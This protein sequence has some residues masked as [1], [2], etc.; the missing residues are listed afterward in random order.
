MGSVGVHAF[1]RLCVSCRGN[2]AGSVHLV[3]LM[4]HASRTAVL[5]ASRH[6][7]QMLYFLVVQH[8]LRTLSMQVDSCGSTQTASSLKVGH[9]C[10]HG[11]LALLPVCAL[12]SASALGVGTAMKA[13]AGAY[14]GSSD[15]Y[16]VHLAGLLIS[17]LLQLATASAHVV[18]LCHR[19]CHTLWRICYAAA[20]S[21][22]TVSL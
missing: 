16:E 5:V 8:L 18:H 22:G 21:S 3:G 14:A 11:V 6:P 12:A 1:C 10:L 13:R 15:S 7:W 2:S 4:P 20:A 9:A 17:A 19:L